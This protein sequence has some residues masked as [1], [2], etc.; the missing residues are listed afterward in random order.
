[1]TGA[2][3]E[4]HGLDTTTYRA[5]LAHLPGGV[6]VLTTRDRGRDHAMVVTSL[7]SYSIEPPT[8]LVSLHLD[9]RLAPLLEEGRTWAASIVAPGAQNAVA[10]LTEPGRPDLGQLQGVA[11]RRGEATGAAIVTP[12]AAWVECETERVIE[13]RDHV[14]VL[15]HVLAAGAGTGSGVLLHRL[16]R[17][18]ALDQASGNQADT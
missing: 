1:M 5:A 13:H 7:V 18:R 16:G 11:H 9:S 6:V 12:N 15:G 2:D 14:L 8:V 10:W 17:V 4:T 3:G